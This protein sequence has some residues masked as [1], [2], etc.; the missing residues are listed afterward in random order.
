[1][2]LSHKPEFRDGE[3]INQKASDFI[4][5]DTWQWDRP[6]LYETLKYLHQGRG[7]RF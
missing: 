3:N 5:T 6:K 4:D 1:M 7:G 2:W